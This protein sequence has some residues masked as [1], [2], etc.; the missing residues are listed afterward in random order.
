VA[1]DLEPLELRRLK[2]DLVLYYECLH[3]LVAL[4]SSEYFTMSYFTSQTTSLIAVY[5]VGIVYHL[6]CFK[7]L[8]SNVDLS[9]FTYCT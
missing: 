9:T 4:P 7:R 3:D 1:P 6:Q 8:L 2:S 5:F